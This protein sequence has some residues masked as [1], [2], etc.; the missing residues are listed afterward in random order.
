MARQDR[1]PHQT[2][3]PAQQAK[4]F[5]RQA[6]QFTHLRLCRQR[7]A[8]ARSNRES[9][10]RQFSW[11]LPDNAIFSQ[12]LF[13]ANTKWSPCH[14]VYLIFCWSLID[15]T[16]LT[17]AFAQA[18]GRCSFLFPA[19]SFTYQGFMGALLTWT[20]YFIPLLR[21]LLH[22]R[23]PESNS[24]YW[25]VHGWIP[26]SFDGSRSTAPRTK[27][28]EDAFCA[29]NYGKSATARSRKKKNKTKQAQR[30][31]KKKTQPQEPQVWITLMM[32]MGLRLPW[33]WR[34]GPSNSDE[35]A[36]VMEMVKTE[37]FPEHT[38][39]CGDAGFVGNPLW[40]AMAEKG[41][42]FLVRVGGNVSLLSEEEGFKLNPV[43]DRE[44]AVLSWPKEAIQ[45]QK[46]PLRLR[47]VHVC[48]GKTWMW[49]LTNELDSAKL[50]FEHMREFY[51]MRWGVEIE[52]R[53]LK[54]TLHRAKLRCRN[55]KR[56]LVELDWAVMTMA[57][58]EL[59]ASKEQ[60]AERTEKKEAAAKPVKRSLALAARA[61][62]DCFRELD[63]I[64]PPGQDL[65]SKLRAAV[66]DDYIRK[67]SKKARYR[68]PNPDK[69]PLQ[70]PKVRAV[71][72]QESERLREIAASNTE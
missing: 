15:N 26:I 70:D 45:R 61:F 43:G 27:A 30:V 37:T 13:H 6:K 50:S 12:L 55:P 56:L 34:L 35:R 69:S 20:P 24:P 39:F 7:R 8:V 2:R 51:K 32:P 63:K 29:P 42:R 9:L 25:S 28:N 14:L 41:H 54:Q 19:L 60:Q 17:D 72:K 59:L 48:V 21:E 22:C 67:S 44:Y 40:Q 57:V 16:I 71:N 38:L 46:L 3:R 31:R 66:T 36:H 49:L 65:G 47:L 52:F 68:P 1:R 53:G 62:R 58:V 11:F 23:M 18:F 33:S 10:Q 5:S 4:R 64:P